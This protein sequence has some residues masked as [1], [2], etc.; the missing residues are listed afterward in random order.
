MVPTARSISVTVQQMTTNKVVTWIAQRGTI[1]A[2]AYVAPSSPGTRHRY[3]EQH[4]RHQQILVTATVAV[5]APWLRRASGLS[6][7]EG[8]G[9]AVGG[10]G[11]Q[12]FESPT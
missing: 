5:S 6:G 9:A 10:R 12:V 2:G 8:G 4:R 7:A 3:C 11:G 1:S